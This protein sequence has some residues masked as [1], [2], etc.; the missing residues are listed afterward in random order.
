MIFDHINNIETYKGL[1]PDI[2]EGLKFLLQAFL[3]IAV[4]TYQINPRVKAI[5]SEYETKQVNGHGF[6]AHKKNIDIQY[7]L[8]G[9]EQIACL[10]IEKLTEAEPYNEQ[11]DVAFYAADG[12]RAQ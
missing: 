6:E 1:S 11:K 8:K 2:Y 3:D 12:V 4:G 7:L 5:V 10:L 9:E